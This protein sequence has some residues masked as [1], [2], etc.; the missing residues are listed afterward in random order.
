MEVGGFCSTQSFKDPG[1]FP[2]VPGAQGQRTATGS[3]QGP[4]LEVS[5][6][7]S[8]LIPLAHILLHGPTQLKG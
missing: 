8:V 4:G 7:T 2:R 6:V 3:V 1:S 5:N